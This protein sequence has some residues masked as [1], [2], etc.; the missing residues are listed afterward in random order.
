MRSPPVKEGDWVIV[1]GVH[2]VVAEVLSSQF[3]C[4][5]DDGRE[6]LFVL[7]SSPGW[8]KIE[9]GKSNEQ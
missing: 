8:T 4:D 1:D 2:G 9:K 5:L 6:G 3:T 7:Y